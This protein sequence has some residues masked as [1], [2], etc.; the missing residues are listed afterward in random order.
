MELSVFRLLETELWIK[1]THAEMLPLHF[2]RCEEN[3]LETFR[4]LTRHAGRGVHKNGAAIIVMVIVGN[5][6]MGPYS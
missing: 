6:T 2:Q 5:N 4:I 1:C 3:G